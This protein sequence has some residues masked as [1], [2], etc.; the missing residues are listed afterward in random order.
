MRENDI[1]SSLVCGGTM[2]RY[3]D[4]L[5][6]IDKRHKIYKHFIKSAKNIARECN[7]L[8]YCSTKDFMRYLIK[9]KKIAE[10][11]VTG[12]ISLYYFAAIPNFKKIIPK[13]DLFARD[14]F[15]KIYDRF[16]MYNAEITDAFMKIT[17]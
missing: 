16:E 13:L 3:A 15:H 2:A 5:K 12:K 17:N 4:W 10:Y 1:N 7:E 6:A 8:G 9:S 11:Y 14:E